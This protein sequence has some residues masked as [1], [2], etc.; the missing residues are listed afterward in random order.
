MT[1]NVFKKKKVVFLLTLLFCGFLFFVVNGQKPGFHFENITSKQ[2]LADVNISA[3]IQDKQGFIWIGSED[4]LTRY[5]G[6]NCV[7]YRHKNNDPYSLSDNEIYALCVDGDG[8]LWAGTPNGLNRYDNQTDRFENFFHSTTDT[9]SLA[10]NNVFTLAKDNDGNLWTGTYGGG[11]DKVEKVKNKAGRNDTRYIFKHYRH[12]DGDSTSISSNQVLSLC[13]DKNNR[14]WAGTS[15]ALNVLD[16]NTGKFSHFYHKPE[17]NNSISRNDVYEIFA[18]RNGSMWLCGKG[19]LDKIIFPLPTAGGSM[20]VTHYLPK[21]AGKTNLNEWAISDFVIDND[22]NAWMATNDQGLIKFR[23][24]PDGE[25]D[26][27]DQFIAK[28]GSSLNLVN[29]IIAKF[30]LDRSGI[31]WIGTAKGVSKYIPSKNRFNEINLPE[32]AFRPDQHTITSLLSDNRNRLWLGYDTD[33]V[34]V[35]NKD[36]SSSVSIKLRPHLSSASGFDQVNVMYQSKAGDTYIGTLVQGLFIIP[37]SL[38]NIYDKKNWI[39][40][41]VDKFPALPNKNIYAIT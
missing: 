39:H 21:L 1:A 35:I 37:G 16:K 17:D 20:S 36:G 29:S 9:N 2:G 38:K 11:L 31:L 32:N 13:F 30:Y 6:Y 19:M 34:T 15:N 23:I 24:G 28:G 25:V 5:D 10:G 18:A 8:V 40:I 33:T 12:I 3:V 26:S 14:A 7:V 27:Y 4:G 41:N 22:N